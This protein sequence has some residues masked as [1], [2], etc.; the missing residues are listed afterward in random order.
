MQPLDLVRSCDGCTLCCKIMEI[1]ELEKP[2]GKW[3][4]QCDIGSGCR[5]YDGRPASCA[6]FTC[7]YLSWPPVAERWNPKKC[8]MVI[9][10]DKPDQVVVRVDES[11]PDAWK[12]EPFY[13]DLKFWAKMGGSEQQLLVHS[14]GRTIAIV[15][16]QDIDLGVVTRSD[17]LVTIELKTPMGV[18][19]VVEKT[20]VFDSRISGFPISR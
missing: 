19:W 8:K 17:V 12:A 1:E 14:R 5:I 15:P 3:C 16:D 11:R 4:G 13:S 20:S 9:T 7:G 18:R 10:T 6:A 2:P